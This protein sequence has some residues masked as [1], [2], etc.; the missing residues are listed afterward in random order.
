MIYAELTTIPRVL[1]LGATD[2]ELRKKE[3][4]SALTQGSKRNMR[5]TTKTSV[6]NLPMRL[7]RLLLLIFKS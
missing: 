2:K 3:K 1:E 4:D 6:R 7:M 5:S